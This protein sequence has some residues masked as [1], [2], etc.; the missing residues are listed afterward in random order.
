MCIRIIIFNKIIGIMKKYK[1]KFRERDEVTKMKI[2]ESLCGR[3]KSAEH[4]QAISQAL[5]D[6][7]KGVPSLKKDLGQN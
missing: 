4:R 2:S 7:W 1:R 6:Y 5:K 3:M